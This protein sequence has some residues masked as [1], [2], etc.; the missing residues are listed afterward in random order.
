MEMDLAIV[1]VYLVVTLV[2][3]IWSGRQVWTIREFAVDPGRTSSLAMYATIYATYI[4]GGSTMGMAEKAFSSGLVFP[5]I[6]F[7]GSLDLMFIGLFIA[8]KMERFLGSA[9]SPGG[10]AKIFWGP[11]GE[12]VTGIMGMFFSVGRVAA[13]VSTIGYIFHHML[14]ISFEGGVCL[15]F[16][17]LVFYSS[18]GG[19]RSVIATDVI[20]YVVLIVSF[21]IVTYLAVANAGGFSAMWEAVPAD[22]LTLAPIWEE[23]M[24]YPPI[25]IL[26]LTALASPAWIQRLLMGKDSRQL[27]RTFCSASCTLPIAFVCSTLVGLSALVTS[28]EIDSHSAMAYTVQT[29]L[30]AGL[31]GL[32]ISGLLAV[33][34][35]TADSFLN[36]A[37]V[38]LVCDVLAPWTEKG[39][40]DKEMLRYARWAT[41]GIGVFSMIVSLYFK[42]VIDILLY[43]NSFWDGTVVLPLTASLLGYVSTK[44]AFKWSTGV[45]FTISV[46]WI[47]FDLEKKTGVYG[48]CPA[49]IVNAFLFFGLSAYGKRRGVLE[50]EARERLPHRC[51]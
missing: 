3:G 23:P 18:F 32:V 1:A 7:I 27:K 13:Q 46:L 34:M 42:D 51:A 19:I 15:G 14:G 21:P 6:Y 40:P 22:H 33:L 49:M 31:R 16:G 30:P 20:Q 28:P 26:F 25:I 38:M 50:C 24:R 9:I 48:F 5:L 36:V 10:F 43:F 8:P 11:V 35:S 44:Q 29:V 4:G 39:I 17:L 2:L 41:F 37:G 47:L 12:R 45:G